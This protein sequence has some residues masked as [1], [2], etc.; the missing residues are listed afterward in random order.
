LLEGK[1]VNLRVAE[2][3]RDDID[4]LVEY[5]NDI[6]IEGEYIPIEQTSKS[7]WIEAFDN[8]VNF[9]EG[10]MLIIQ[11]KDGTRIGLVNHRFN[12]PYK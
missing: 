7:E 2:R 12:K 8:P 4:F 3:E 5:T 6:D 9:T 10:E 11:K 1:N